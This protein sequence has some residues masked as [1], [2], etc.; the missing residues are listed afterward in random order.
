MS[1]PR[2]ARTRTPRQLPLQRGLHARLRQARAQPRCG[3]RENRVD[4]RLAAER[5]DP[6]ARQHHAAQ[7]RVH[8]QPGRERRRPVRA[9][10]RA[11]QAQL[12]QRRVDGQRVAERGCALGARNRVVQD[13]G[14]D[15][16]GEAEL[17]GEE[18]H[19]S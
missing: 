8:A 7:C 9:D 10:P 11:T 1:R 12:G 18:R 2:D 6:R 4:Q 19:A 3:R 17:L 13:E 16:G 5:A 15:G 14:L